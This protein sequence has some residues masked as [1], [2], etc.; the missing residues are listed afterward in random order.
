MKK[1]FDIWILLSN[2]YEHFVENVLSKEDVK[3]SWHSYQNGGI[4]SALILK[5]FTQ[6]LQYINKL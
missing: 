4:V 5:D 3:E 1:T 2:K 6:Y